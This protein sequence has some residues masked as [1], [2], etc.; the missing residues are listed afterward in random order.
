MSTIKRLLAFTI[1][2]LAIISPITASA[3]SNI[4]ETKPRLVINIVVGQLRYD[5]LIRYNE[6]LST[7]G[8]R[9]LISEGA[10]CQQASYNF[11]ATSTPA[12]LATLTTGANPS[13]HGIIGPEWFNYTTGERV[14]LLEDKSVQTIGAD[15][16]DTQLSPKSLIATTVGDALKSSSPFSKVIS[17]AFDPLSAILTGGVAADAAYW[18]NHRKGDF[19]SSSYY[20][21]RLPDWVNVF[22]QK[23]MA[24]QHGSTPWRISHS[25]STFKNFQKTDIK[26]DNS[27]GLLDWAKR[28]DWDFDNFKA[29]PFANTYLRDFAVQTIIHEKLGTDKHTDMLNIVFDPSRYVG[30]KYGTQSMETEDCF[31]RMDKE[32]ASILEYISSQFKPED[33]LVVLSS[34]HGAVDQLSETSRNPSGIFNSHQ[35]SILMNG[36]I[37]AKIGGDKKWVLDFMNNQVYLDRAELYR[38]GHSIEDVQNLIAEFAIQFKGVSRGITG[39]S[40]TKDYFTGGIMGKAQNS[41]FERTS[42]DV[43]LCLLPG[44]AAGNGKLSDSG[45][46][47]NYDTHVPLMFWGGGIKNQKVMRTVDLCDV[48][49]TISSLIGIAP[50]LAAT[51]GTII[52]LHNR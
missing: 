6:N 20:L 33:V 30:E 43:T 34:D 22:N 11:L 14:R 40:L 2:T 50:P 5:Y 36:F 41:F 16:Y 47:Y 12:G 8:F 35:F 10:T 21:N 24:Q 46:P 9:A 39:S 52:E 51:G 48:A 37:G 25:A 27:E 26:A 49:P 15:H 32:I 3:N 28:K 31:Y 45:S 18:V 19:V 38:K 4:T 29:T 42:G 13:T 17:I 44:W 23:E 7:K 1:I